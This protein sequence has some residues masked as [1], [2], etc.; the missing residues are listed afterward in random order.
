LRTIVAILAVV[1]VILQ[2]QVWRQ[3]ARV[4][5]LEARV[6]AQRE[7][8]GQLAA[9]N[10]ALAAEVDDLQS[11]LEAVEE[12]ARA[13]LGLIRDGESFYLVV[14]PDDLNPEDAEALRRAREAEPSP[15]PQSATESDPAGDG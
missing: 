1:L 11:G 14:E 5:E 3:F 8:N 13:E 9:R 12:R 6:E 7:E 10:A 4:A 2:V 15:P